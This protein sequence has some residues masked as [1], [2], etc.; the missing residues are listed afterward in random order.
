MELREP[1]ID[2]ITMIR[3]SIKSGNKRIMLAA[4]T[5]FGKTMVAASILKST[6]DKGNQGMMICDR[7]NLINQSLG[8]FDAQGLDLGVIQGIHERH[9]PM[10]PIQI[11]SVQ[12]LS[13]RSRLPIADIYIIDEAHIHY[14][15]VTDL[16]KAHNNCIFIGLSA[17]PYSKGLGEH[18]QDLIVPITPMELLDQGYLCP[19]DYFIGHNTDLTGV[20]SQGLSTGGSD[21]AVKDLDQAMMKDEVLNGDIIKNWVQHGENSQTIAFTPSIK[22]SEWLVEQFNEY[23]VSAIHIDCDT[24]PDVRKEMFDA[25]N[26]GEFKILSCSQLLNTGYDS[27]S[28]RCIIDC[29]PTKSKIVYVQRVGRI[30]RIAENKP[31]AIY[32]DHAGNWKRHGRAEH[33]VPDHLDDGEKQYNE[34]SLTKKETKE[35]K[36]RNCPKCYQLFTGRMCPCGYSLTKSEVIEHDGSDLVKLKDM[37]KAERRGHEAPQAEK[38]LTLAGLRL[39]MEKKNYSFGWVRH[40]FKEMYGDFPHGNSKVTIT[41]MPENV[42]KFIIGKNIRLKYSRQAHDKVMKQVAK[43]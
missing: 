41:Q 18:Y 37:S 31:N 8:Q 4:P 15:F 22:Q 36:E 40:T 19:V 32:L 35:A 2:A 26:A 5:S 30:M 11:A 10:A 28:T 12:T 34:E 24:K 42:K 6:Q 20:K 1:Q 14:Q 9:N 16:M 17:T 33:L 43:L 38:D 29:F 23:G 7:I 25:H 39:H 3:A 13:R 21:Y 27:P